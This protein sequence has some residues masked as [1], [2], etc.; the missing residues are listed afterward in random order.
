MTATV[1]KY[2]KVL[3]LG[4]SL[5]QVGAINNLANTHPGHLNS[6]LFHLKDSGARFWLLGYSELLTLF[7]ED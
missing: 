5:T 2:S 6:F 4:D 7:V 1:N 3:L